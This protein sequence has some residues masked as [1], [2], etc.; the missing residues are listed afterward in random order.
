MMSC[1]RGKGEKSLSPV[2]VSS[3]Q[4]LLKIWDERPLLNDDRWLAF[5]LG[6]I[7]YETGDFRVQIENMSYG[8]AERISAIW[9]RE[10][11]TPESAAAYVNNPE[12]LANRIYGK[13]LGNTE[14]GDGFR[15][16]GRG[17]VSL[18]GRANYRKYGQIIG[19]D[20][21]AQPDLM[22]KPE[23]GAR[24]AFEQFLP[25]EK[26]PILAQYFNKDK[27]DWAG[28][29]GTFVGGAT[30]AAAVTSRSKA[31]LQCIKEATIERI[32]AK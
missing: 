32:A 6:S 30:G 29:R 18:T 26:S 23:I 1:Y 13:R 24:V 10:F 7:A 4:E 16:R 20:L 12:A 3:L 9:R 15:Y 17:M 2:Q 8:S 21:E 22:L 5:I 14:E 19:V 28:A 31:F 27:E 25:A 11:P